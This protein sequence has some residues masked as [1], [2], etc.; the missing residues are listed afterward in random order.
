MAMGYKKKWDQSE[1]V[2]T[3]QL[4]KYAAMLANKGKR[5]Q[6]LLVDKIST[7]DGQ[8]PER[9]QPKVL[10]EMDSP[11]EDWN[12]IYQGMAQVHTEGFDDYNLRT[13]QHIAKNGDIDARSFRGNCG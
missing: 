7:Y 11:D 5:M 6:P 8:V 3:L 12:A 10:N 1:K 13:R 9:S 2:T 4:A